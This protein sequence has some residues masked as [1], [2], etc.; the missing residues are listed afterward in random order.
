MEFGVPIPV[1]SAA[2]GRSGSGGGSAPASRW[3]RD[4]RTSASWEPPAG[5]SRRP[6]VDHGFS[7]SGRSRSA[8][9]PRIEPRNSGSG[10]RPPGPRSCTRGIRIP[11]IRLRRTPPRNSDTRSRPPRPAS[12]RRGRGTARRDR[13]RPPWRVSVSPRRRPPPIPGFAGD[14]LE[15]LEDFAV[16]FLAFHDRGEDLID[17]PT[18]LHGHVDRIHASADVEQG[19]VRLARR[20]HARVRVD[21]S[22]TDGTDFLFFRWRKP[23]PRT[24]RHVSIWKLRTK[25]FRTQSRE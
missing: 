17:A 20:A 24:R 18:V 19:Q 16:V 6:G 8:R 12:R 22:V 13:P 25:T 14:V 1:G 4:L 5:R 21:W 7:P 11:S 10:P 3:P 2:T 9:L 15:R 23:T